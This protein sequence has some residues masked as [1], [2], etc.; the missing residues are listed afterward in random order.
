M[1]QKQKTSHYFLSASEPVAKVL[2]FV[3][4]A[5]MVL[6][7]LPLLAE[8][9]YEAQITATES[10]VSSYKE[11][12]VRLAAEA[13]Q[14]EVRLAR[15]DAQLASVNAEIRKNKQQFERL[16]MELEVREA[17]V[18]DRSDDVE[19]V[20][21]QAYFDSQMSVVEMLASRNSLSHYMDYYAVRDRIQSELQDDL[22]VLKDAKAEIEAQREAIAAVLRDGRSM[23]DTL[24][25][26]REEQAELLE[27]TR[28][29]QRAYAQ[30]VK[31]RNATIA[32]LRAQQLSANQS[33]FAAGEII[34]GDPNRGGY[35]DK[36]DNAPQDSLVDPWG[37]YNRECVSYTAWKVHQTTGHMPY[38]G[39][40]GNANQWPA[41]AR[42][43]DIPTGTTP[44]KHAV[45]IAFIG[46]YGHAMFVEEVLGNGNIRISE[47]N[48]FVDGTYTERIIPGDGLT[49]IYFK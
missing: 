10:S 11:Q 47:Y 38:W 2:M 30:L 28:G 19:A 18:A 13:E 12:Q 37:M 14:I 29:Q 9:A 20:L 48:Y 23:R 21:R 26:K 33:Y 24:Q 36:L 25:Q 32:A 41:S 35:P 8:G 3:S 6:S 43:V 1:V 34:K 45:A 27:R 46:P 17:E 15:L 39:G 49:Y 7:P 22:G 42:A 16:S 5:V 31:E 4:A 40:H 44:K